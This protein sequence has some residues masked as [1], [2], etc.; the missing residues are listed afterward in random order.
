MEERANHGLFLRQLG[1]EDGVATC[2]FLS[3]TISSFFWISQHTHT[4]VETEKNG[5][6]QLSNDLI[7][8]NIRK[9]G[10]YSF[11]A[12]SLWNF[13]PSPLFNFSLV[14]LGGK[15]EKL[16]MKKISFYLSC[17]KDDDD[18][19]GLWTL[20]FLRSNSSLHYWLFVD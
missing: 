15:S 4:A 11:L 5:N 10:F 8:V 12:L 6:S 2:L 20:L 19:D 17:E 13:L 18:E 1:L 7:W 14:S 9:K 3:W 16:S